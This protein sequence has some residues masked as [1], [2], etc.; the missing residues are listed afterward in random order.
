MEVY[1]PSEQHLRLSTTFRQILQGSYIIIM[2]LRKT[3]AATNLNIVRKERGLP[4]YEKT[5]IYYTSFRVV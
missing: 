4:L 3:K 1:F 2:D 5:K